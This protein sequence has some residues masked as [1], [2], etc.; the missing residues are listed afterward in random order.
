MRFRTTAVA[1][2][3]CTGIVAAIVAGG[4]A[5]AAPTVLV[6]GHARACAGTYATISSAVTAAVAGDTIEVCAGTY[7]ETVNVDTPDLTFV[8]AQAG[9]KGTAARAADL[10]RE[11]VVSDVNGDFVLGAGA[12]HTTISGFALEGAGSPTVDHDGIEAFAGSSGLDVSDDVIV[13]NGN[14]INLQ[15]PETDNPA[16]ISHNYIWDNNAEGDLGANDSTGTGVFISNGPADDTSI[17]HNVFGDDSQT[18]INF[19]GGASPS[20]GLV[21]AG[22]TSLDDSTFVVAV[23]S[24]N[25]TI[26]DN[27]ITVDGTVPGGNG[28]GI[29]DF[30]GNTGLRILK[31]T[32][33][34]DSDISAAIALSAYDGS[35]S[36]GTTVTAN[37]V[38]GWDDGVSAAAGYTTALISSNRI[39]HNGAFGISI[40]AD[41]GGNVLSQNRVS[42]DSGVA[43]DCSDLSTG[44]LTAGTANTWLRNVGADHDST[45]R[46]I[47]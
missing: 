18:A 38:S 35:A 3:L 23:N 33:S 7:D 29:L 36:V 42:S 45:P 40:D 13:G 11:S 1:A 47:C 5:N 8:G 39:S 46:G 15:N 34:S 37:T 10:A 28:T 19:A 12:D 14:G 25:A 16:T 41:T 22:N 31:N 24:V 6:V 20:Q 32:M 43:V 44:S 17:N 9:N 4:A 27:R 21:V 2:V 26:Q 30:G